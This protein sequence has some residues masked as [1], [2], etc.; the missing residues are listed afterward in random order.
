MPV[1][2]K[3]CLATELACLYLRLVETYG[4]LNYE[5]LK[6]LSLKASKLKGLKK[7]FLS[8]R[9]KAR[10]IEV[11]MIERFIELKTES[12]EDRRIHD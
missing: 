7:S 6:T 12:L 4:L 11:R 5:G 1:A 9:L 10:K 8:L 2:S 3:M